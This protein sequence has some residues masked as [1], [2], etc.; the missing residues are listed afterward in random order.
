MGLFDKLAFWKK[1]TNPHCVVVLY[2]SKACRQRMY[3]GTFKVHPLNP[4][5]VTVDIEAY[6]EY[7]PNFTGERIDELLSKEVLTT[8]EKKELNHLLGNSGEVVTLR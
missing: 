5:K 6:T 3:K 4:S 2:D 1:K 8:K 7:I